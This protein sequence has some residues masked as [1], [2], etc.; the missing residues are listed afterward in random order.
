M[1]KNNSQDNIFDKIEKNLNDVQSSNYK[2]VFENEIDGKIKKNE[3][4]HNISNVIKTNT[5]HSLDEQLNVDFE[6]ENINILKIF[7]VDPDI[8]KYSQINKNNIFS[9]NNIEFIH[10]INLNLSN[11]ID[12]DYFSDDNHRK[13]LKNE[14]KKK[15]ENPKSHFNEINP[16][17]NISNYIT[18]I[19]DVV[20]IQNL[21]TGSFQV[22]ESKAIIK[23]DNINLIDFEDEKKISNI[24]L[25]NKNSLKPINEKIQEKNCES[26]QSNLELK[27]ETNEIFNLTKNHITNYTITTQ[28]NIIEENN[29][30]VL[31]MKDDN[32]NNIIE[33]NFTKLSFNENL[34]ES[35]NCNN[36]PEIKLN[37]QCTFNSAGVN[38]QKPPLTS[39]NIRQPAETEL[40]KQL[41]LRKL[42]K[43][44]ETNI[45]NVNLI[46]KLKESIDNDQPLLLYNVK[47]PK[48]NKKYTTYIESKKTKN[49]NFFFDYE[50]S[51]K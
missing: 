12:Y 25:S 29:D 22:N 14:K 16:N 34:N 30:H 13:N 45:S 50:F 31:K 8:L 37:N 15:I 42:A 18:K 33:T 28:N 2:N 20:N 51:S 40:K 7:E 23:N 49:K 17:V 48:L 10:H 46:K 3:S 26:Y 5:K 6:T 19:V 27:K 24:N 11:S 4:I 43:N 32:I 36:P 1:S 44:A 38:I 39:R 35:N 47:L 41:L 21:S 9:M